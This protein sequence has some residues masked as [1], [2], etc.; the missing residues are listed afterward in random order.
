MRGSAA[1]SPTPWSRREHD[2]EKWF[3]GFRTRS[4]SKRAAERLLLGAAERAGRR[5]AAAVL[6]LVAGH[7][8]VLALGLR[9]L[10]FL[11]LA[12]LSLGHDGFSCSGLDGPRA[13][14]NL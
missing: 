5:A 8:L 9:L 1:T 11:G 6:R 10:L 3:T 4:C 14:A 13:S 2:P 12:L 7:R